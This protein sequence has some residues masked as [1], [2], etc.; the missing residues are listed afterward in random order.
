[1]QPEVNSV[2]VYGTLRLG[3]PRHDA[4]LGPHLTGPPVPAVLRAARLHA[5]PGF[6]YLAPGDPHETV[7]GEL[8]TVSCGSWARVLRDLDRMEGH[9]AHKPER[10]LYTSRLV[11]VLAGTGQTRAAWTYFA[12]PAV[13]AELR[14]GTVVAGGDWFTRPVRP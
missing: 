12:G 11:R 10:G 3:G 9:L 5:G 8:V 13:I 6:P 2:F 7:T 1:M 14:S 4:F